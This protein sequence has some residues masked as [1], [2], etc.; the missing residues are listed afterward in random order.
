M[1]YSP[2][3]PDRPRER[4]QNHLDLLDSSAGLVAELKKLVPDPRYPA[5]ATAQADL[6]NLTNAD[7]AWRAQVKILMN[8]PS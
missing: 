1:P 4:W 6:D 8:S 5:F 2:S 7:D 3:I